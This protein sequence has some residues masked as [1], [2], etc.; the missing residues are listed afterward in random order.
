MADR[1]RELVRQ[2]GDGQLGTFLEHDHLGA[3]RSLGAVHGGVGTLQQI[4]RCIIGGGDGETEA[5]RDMQQI[6]AHF[7]RCTTHRLAET[8]GDLPRGLCL[9]EPIDEHHEF[10]AAEPSD[11]VAGAQTA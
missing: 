2:C 11:R 8:C 3:A 6:A 10:V 7:D 1:E 4:G 9:V 5:G